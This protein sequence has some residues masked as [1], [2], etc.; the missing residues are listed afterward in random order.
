MR[1]PRSLDL[2]S[3]AIFALLFT[4][5]YVFAAPTDTSPIRRARDLLVERS[6]T[7]KDNGCACIVGSAQGQYCWGCS[8]GVINGGDTSVWNSDWQSWV[9]EC[10]PDG[11]CCAYGLRFSCEAGAGTPVSPCGPMATV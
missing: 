1:S 7:C 10:N 2:A 6:D 4:M 5:Y 9:F 8:N 3:L 11:G